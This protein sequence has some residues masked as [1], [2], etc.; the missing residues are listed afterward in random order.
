VSGPDD[1][2]STRQAALHD[3]PICSRACDMCPV[4][5]EGGSVEVV[6]AVVSENV[7]LL[8][9]GGTPDPHRAVLGSAEYLAIVRREPR[10]ADA[11]VAA[12]RGL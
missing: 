8:A 2:W 1:R 12:Q 11:G 5:V 7:L 9:T 6:A 10:I 3:L 4:M